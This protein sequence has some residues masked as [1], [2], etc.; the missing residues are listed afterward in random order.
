DDDEFDV[1][2]VSDS[3]ASANT[4]AEN[5]SAGDTVGVTAFASDEDG[6]TNDVEYSLST[7]PNDAFAI[8]PETGVVTVADP[9]GLDFETAQSMQIE[10]LATSEDGSTSSQTF[11]IAIT[12]HNE[13]D[14]SALSDVWGSSRTVSEEA[15]DD[16]SVFRVRAEDYDGTNNEVTYELTE[17]PGNA[18]RISSNGT[19]QVNDANAIDFEVTPEI[20]I[21]ITATS[22]DGSST[23]QQY[24]VTVNDVNEFNVSPVTDT[25]ATA[26]SISENVSAGDTVGVTAF[27]SDDDGSNN[28]VTYALTDNPNDA[29]AIDAESGVVTVADP[30]AIDFET[31]DSMRIEVT[32]TSDD[33]STSSQRFTIEIND[34]DEFDVTAISDSDGDANTVRENAVDGVYVGLTAS[35][36]D[37]DGT[38][39]DVTFSLSDDANGTFAIDAETGEVTVADASQLDF[40]SAQSMRIEVTATSEDGSVST[41]DY[42]IAIGDHNEFHVT[43]PSDTD[44]TANSVAEDASAG[45]VVGVTVFAEDADGSTNE[46]SYELVSNPNDAFAI[47]AETG[48]VTVADPNG[49]NF[50]S[51]RSMRIEV[52]ATSEDGSSTTESFDIAI[53][54]VDEFDV[55]AV[56]D[57]DGAANT[58]SEHAI[59]GTRVGVTAVADDA[60]GSNSDVTYTLTA[61]PG[62]AFAIGASSGVVTVADSNALDFESSDSMQIEVTATSQ[63]GSSSVQTFDIAIS[64]HNEFH[65]SRITDDDAGA[66]A[67][68]TTAS[69]GDTVAVTAQADDT[70][71]TNSEVTYTLSDDAGGAFTIDSSSGVVTIADPGA[72][73][74]GTAQIEVT[75]TS[76]DGSSTTQLFDIDVVD[77]SHGGGAGGGG[78]GA[79][80]DHDVSAISDTDADGN[81]VSEHAGEG[82]TVGIAA[83]AD[84]ADS[85]DSV[86]YSLS[87]NPGDAF[88]IDATTGVVSV[89]DSSAIDYETASTMQIEV[90]ATSTD[91][92]T[93][94]QTFDI[95]IADHDEFA[96]K[97]VSDADTDANTVSEQASVGDTVGITAFASD[98][99]G[100]N[101]GVTYSLSDDADG[102]FTIDPDSGVVTV[103]DASAIDYESDASMRIEVTATSDDGSSTTQSFSVAVTDHDEFDVG[104]I[105]DSDASNPTILENA[106]TGQRVGVTASASDADGSTNEITYSL[107]E[108]PGSAF[109]IDP[110]SGVVTVADSNALD[111]EA[112]ETVQIEVTATSADGSSSTQTVDIT[113]GDHDEFHISGLSDT[114]ASANLVSENAQAGDQVGLTVF[115]VDED[116]TNSDVSYE[117]LSDGGGAFAID[118]D[119]GVVTVAD[120]SALD[121]ESRDTMRI[122]VQAT[123]EDGT[124]SSRTFRISIDDHDEFDVSAVIDSDSAANLVGENAEDG[125]YVGVA[126]FASDGDGTSSDVTYSLTENPS[127]AFAIDPLTG[128]VTLADSSAIDHESASSMQIEVTATSADGSSS[129]QTFDIEIGD[130]DEFNISSISDIDADANAV[131][132]SAGVGV[133]VGI[134]GF[135]SDADGTDNV[136]Y[137]LTHNQNN[138]FAIDPDT[139]EV[140]VADPSG[141]DFEDDASMRIAIRAESDDGSRSSR[142]YTVNLTDEN[143][144]AVTPISDTDAA[145][146]SIAEDVSAGD[147]VG[148]TA[149]A[150]DDDG[151]NNE[152]TYSLTQNPNDAFAIDA[153]TGEVTVADPAAIDA[154]TAASMQIEV[155]ATSEDGSTSAQTYDINV[156]DVDEFDA[157]AV[158]DTDTAANQV[159]DTASSGDSVGVT[160]SSTDGDL[161]DGITYALSDDHNGAFVIDENTGEIS[162]GDE[163][164]LAALGG[165]SVDLEV[166]ASSTDGSNSVQTF[167]VDVEWDSSAPVLT[168]TAAGISDHSLAMSATVVNGDGVGSLEGGLVTVSAIAADGSAG[169]VNAFSGGVGVDGGRHSTQIDQAEQIV[170]DFE[171]YA[172]DITL[173]TTRQYEGEGA[174]GEEGEWIALDADGNEVARGSLLVAD[175]TNVGVN[176]YEYTIDPGQ[177]IAQL[178][179]QPSQ[180]DDYSDFAIKQLDFRH[181]AFDEVGEGIAYAFDVGGSAEAGSSI[182]QVSAFDVDGDSLTYEIISGNDDGHFRIDAATGELFLVDDAST[183]R[184]GDPREGQATLAVRVSDGRGG[185]DTAQVDLT[186]EADIASPYTTPD[187]ATIGTE[188][189]ASV[190]GTYTGSDAAEHLTAGGGSDDISAGGGNDRV[191]GDTGSDTLRGEAGDDYLEGQ[192]QNDTL[193]GGSGDDV[194]MGGE[195]ADQLYGDA[196]D[197]LLVGDTES[198]Q[199]YGGDGDDILEGGAGHDTA[200]GGE[201]S[202]VY[203]F[204][205]NDG[206]DSFSGGEG[207]NDIVH[208]EITP[209]ASDQPFTVTVDG[210]EVT[211]SLSDGVIELGQDTAGTVTFE[212]GAQLNFDGVNRIQFG[213]AET[214]ADEIFTGAAGDN[215]VSGGDGD[216]LYQFFAMDTGVNSFDGGTGWDSV[217]LEV[218][219]G[220]DD[221]PWTI[222]VDGDTLDYDLDA[223]TLDLDADSSGTITYDDGSQLEF[224]RLDNI[225]W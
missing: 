217:E 82:V 136:T 91:G 202:D 81:I 197:D 135:A 177:D 190:S 42:D 24:T 43:M 6:S 30:S 193:H 19:V 178:V 57:S 204:G 186:L 185:E 126:A 130:H 181:Y 216:D 102:A 61:N 94:T 100:S 38:N 51:S 89:A 171:G 109:A 79:V 201:G 194:L 154:E 11:D 170:L 118:A 141:L 44:A 103:A 222:E 208:L 8:D 45:D 18:F 167:G 129:A 158:S 138:A 157:S 174:A 76:Q 153:D 150:S 148:V 203:V 55:T 213:S 155:T 220:T 164:A 7:N 198:D 209:D 85:A 195:G 212:N 14:I 68:S 137:T 219:V 34:F 96:V 104:P 114:N 147:S 31:D 223:G 152:V 200:E 20:Q 72:L 110:S 66:N 86:S 27:A 16:K 60:D 173:T 4:I 52:R 221:T 88:A 119:S 48:V 12:D 123:S 184:D 176:E 151:S 26:N 22:E 115:A 33:G 192:Q 78:G 133:S 3:D 25:D 54:D 112:G 187:V 108:N 65:V 180:A 1:S 211:Y 120:P 99:D 131:S 162:V 125:A 149:F 182:G 40:E 50:E 35:A 53:T 39:S 122:E 128:A 111:Y 215:T 64:D 49:L 134:Q 175:G 189:S 73:S 5:A 59:E 214:A 196:G 105:T 146:N 116:G 67:V 23:S 121:F 172:S 124:T 21:E 41:Q 36:S 87:S 69:A 17:N 210:E 84:D 113:L 142:W 224:E 106:P 80:D 37:D 159:F 127:D 165:E 47:D 63:D 168:T 10:V 28:E 46:V 139:G 144:F 15:T 161:D 183:V 163:H 77:P 205:A 32:A 145:T 90:T 225:F 58:V 191:S 13:F 207:D 29:F 9:N 188:A 132:E 74:H 117:L 56:S 92:S 160:A 2:A 95:T 97:P 75:A 70:D 156:V 166:T 143:E 107:S 62:G 199:L 140:T 206:S 83:F 179:I 169:T 93:A 101:N 71:G 218:P 98:D